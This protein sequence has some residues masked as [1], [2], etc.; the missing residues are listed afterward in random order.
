MTK[1]GFMKL[2]DELDGLR[3]QLPGIQKAIGIAREAG[4]LKE[5]A[6]YHAAR[7]S[8]GM[9]EAKIAE[10][11]A[12][13]SQAKIMDGSN[14]NEDEIQFGATIKLLDLQYNDEEEF[15]LVGDG[16]SDPV[17]NKILP[18]SPMGQAMLNKKVGDVFIV[19]APSGKLEYKVLEITY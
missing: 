8:M 14:V 17:N 6:E 1:A 15:A 2:Q 10:L 4:D 7:E 18:T 3:D 5:N 16:E 11:D 12:R 9:L 13:L 19:D